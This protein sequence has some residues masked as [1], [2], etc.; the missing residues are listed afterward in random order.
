MKIFYIISVA[1]FTLFLNTACSSTETNPDQ[2][3]VVCPQEPAPSPQE[4]IQK[5]ALAFSKAPGLTPDEK[6]RLNDI[7]TRIYMEALEIRQEMG[8]AKSLL[9]R[10][11]AS[12]KYKNKE[13]VDLKNKI[14]KLD[15][16]RL[17][18]MFE[19]LDEVQEVVGHGEENEKLYKFFEDFDPPRTRY[20]EYPR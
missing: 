17:N 10:K 9:F 14:V 16:R 18:L 4:I 19:A 5:A 11:L 2:K 6:T 15:K 20:D 1:V 8:Q 3:A 13:I 7:Y 12:A